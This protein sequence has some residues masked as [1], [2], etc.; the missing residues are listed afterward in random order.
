MSSQD[1]KP[2]RRQRWLPCPGHR[3]FLLL[4][5]GFVECENTNQ[6]VL[7]KS[8]KNLSD[9]EKDILNEKIQQALSDKNVDE[10]LEDFNL[11]FD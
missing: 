10:L 5:N 9:D 11:L 8:I 2:K 6:I 4:N 3:E 7:P 1:P